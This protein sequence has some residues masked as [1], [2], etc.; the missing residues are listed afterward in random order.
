VTRNWRLL[1]GG[2]HS[3]GRHP[4]AAEGDGSQVLVNAVTGKVGT[5]RLSV[6]LTKDQVN[7]FSVHTPARLRR[8]AL[9]QLCDCSRA[10]TGLGLRN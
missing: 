4:Q 2:Y 7:G 1:N 5:S 6:A 10:T 8:I 9:R 3:Q